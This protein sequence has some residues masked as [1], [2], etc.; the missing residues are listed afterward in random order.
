[1]ATIKDTLNARGQTHGSFE[2]NTVITQSLKKIMRSSPN[3]ELLSPPQQ[4]ALDMIM[5]KMA[6]MLTGDTMYIDS[7]RDIVGYAQ[8]MY[9][10]MLIQNG[11]TDTRTHKVKFEDGS[12]S[13]VD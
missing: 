13:D 6:R 11:A 2:A 1:M 8:L 3:W 9:D 7:A 4:E 5:H 10:W 12:W